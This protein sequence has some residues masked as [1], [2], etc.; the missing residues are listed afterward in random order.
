MKKSEKLAYSYNFCSP[1][2]LTMQWHERVKKRLKLRELHTLEAVVQAGSMAK[3]SSQLALS[4]S[5]VS[6]AISEMEHTLG[7]A[8]LERTA[9]G[10]EPTPYAE[11]LLRRS[12]VIFDELS[13]GLTEIEHLKDPTRGNLRIGTPEPTTAIVATVIDRLLAQYPRLTFHVT[14]SDSILHLSSELRERNL[15]LAIFRIASA[16]AGKDLK[17]E[18]LFHDP[19]VV[20]TGKHNPR[21]WH[22]N[23]KL[24]DLMDEPWILPPPQVSIG[25]FIA[26]AFRVRG[27][28]IPKSAVVTSSVH[29]RHNMLATG[30]FMAMLPRVMLRFPVYRETL[31]A[32]PIDLPETRKPIALLS[33]KGR[34][35]SPVAKLFRDCASDVVSTL[36]LER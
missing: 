32:L 21:T 28:S 36:A 23:L 20:M 13:Q 34:N 14:V 12:V 3:A 27:L 31:R 6:K 35:P 16:N 22:R 29:M 1:R 11:I 25:H 17:A 9:H 8:L 15:D 2:G 5:A 26:E 19:L 33:L 10:V 24:S 7:V 4:Q 18:V 30:Q